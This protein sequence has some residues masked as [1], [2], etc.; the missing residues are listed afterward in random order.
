MKQR[1]LTVFAALVSLGLFIKLSSPPLQDTKLAWINWDSLTGRNNFYFKKRQWLADARTIAAGVR[2]LYES[3]TASQINT[4]DVVNVPRSLPPRPG[5]ST[6]L[7][8]IGGT[9]LSSPLAGLRLSRTERIVGRTPLSSLCALLPCS[10][11]PNF[12]PRAYKACYSPNWRQCVMS[13][14]SAQRCTNNGHNA[15]T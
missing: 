14:T 13:R 6:N 8:A 11:S 3:R 4:I 2:Y 15:P 1:I 5:I 7:F 10:R 9:E 12:R